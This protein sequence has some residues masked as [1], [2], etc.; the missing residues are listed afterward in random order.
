[1]VKNLISKCIVCKKKFQR[2]ESQVM[3]SLP[4]ER[5]KPSPPFTNV[6]V[7][8]FGPFRIKGEVQKRVKGKCFGVI[9]T[10]LVSR[11]VYVDVAVN[12]S[13]DA[14]MQ[15]VRR[16]AS[17][18]GWP[19]KFFSDKGSP[20]VAA[21]KELQTMVKVLDWETLSKLSHE[22]GTSWSFSPADSPWYNG[23]TEALI[24]SVKR[25]LNAA[26]AD[27][28]LTFSEFQTVLYETAQLVNQ[29]PIGIHPSDPSEGIYLSSNDLLLGRTT[30]KVPQ[31]PFQER[32][33]LQHRFDF[34][35]RIV[36]S[37]WK[38]WTVEVFPN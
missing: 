28:I 22:R 15:V 24:K 35:Q 27:N 1:M 36:I 3:S 18:R 16:F 33:S 11:A 7:D 12:Y 20:L 31:G 32:S 17:I 4:I 29:R 26:I 25:A 19:K 13:L 2:V 10:C 34:I 37:F 9:M 21:S 6:G 8:L 14:F 30:N 38:R 5:L 23:A